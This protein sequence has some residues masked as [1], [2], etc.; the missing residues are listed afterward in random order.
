M[1]YIETPKTNALKQK[2]EK[3]LKTVPEFVTENNELKINLIKE[4]ADSCDITLIKLLL[5][6]SETKKEFFTSVLDSFVFNSREFKDFL[7][8]SS[9]DNSYSKYLGKEI[10][11]YVG[12]TALTDCGDVVLNFPYKDCVLEGGQRKEDGLDRKSTRLNSSH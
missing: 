4:K 8:F 7:D 12:D 10:G 2:I 5:G 11:L 1:A 3:L 6:N 9:L